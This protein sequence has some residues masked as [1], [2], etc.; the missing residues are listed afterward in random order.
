MNF[1]LDLID[2]PKLKRITINGKRHYV[3]DGVTESEPF[4]SVTSV[5]SADRESQQR[6]HEWRKRVGE[7][8]AN[9]I[10]AKAAG[11]GTKVHNL[12]EDYVQGKPIGDLMPIHLDMFNRLKNVADNSIDNIRLIE[13]QM[14]SR[15][16][17][18]AGTVDMVA[19]FEGKMSVIDW[20]TSTREKTRSKIKNYFRQEAAYAVMFEEITEIP[21]SQLVTVITT[22]DGCCQVFKEKRD[23]WIDD[24]IE[25][26]ELY[27]QKNKM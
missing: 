6:L 7:K 13:G 14:Y 4:P 3:I 20:K 1:N 23:E 5:L 21:V 2:L 19:E 16:L 12:I 10:A 25:L 26:R 15:Y 27:A 18:V 17:K 9:E 24:F 22:E 11:R 8:T